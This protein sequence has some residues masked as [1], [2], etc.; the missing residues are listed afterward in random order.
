MK[1]FKLETNFQET[2]RASEQK[3]KQRKAAN[4]IKYFEQM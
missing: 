3:R 2:I 1:Q 4:L